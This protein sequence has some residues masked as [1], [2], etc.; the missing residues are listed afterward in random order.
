MDWWQKS[1][2]HSRKFSW[3][4]LSPQLRHKNIYREQQWFISMQPCEMK[5]K[6]SLVLL[7]TIIRVCRQNTENINSMINQ[8]NDKPIQEWQT[9]V[10]ASWFNF[11][12]FQFLLNF[13]SRFGEWPGVKLPR[14]SEKLEIEKTLRKERKII[15]ILLAVVCYI[16]LG[17]IIKKQITPNWIIISIKKLFH[18]SI[19][20]PLRK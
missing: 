14:E 20:C 16:P 5:E 2:S 3:K 8:F 11:R 12:L 18:N 10:F 7:L 13:W 19:W 9:N 1:L 15:L 4:N 17:S 6:S